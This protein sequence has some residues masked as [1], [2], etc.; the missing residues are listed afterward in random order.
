MQEQSFQMPQWWYRE[1]RPPSDDAYF[2][3]MSR[4]IIHAGL[5]WYVIDRKWQAIRRAFLGF[6]FEKVARF[7]E[8]DV[9]RLMMDK[10]IVRNRAKIIA[11]IQNALIFRQIV[12]QYGSFQ[13]YLDS[14]DKS[15]NYADAVKELRRKFKRLGPPSASLFLYSVGENINPW[16]Y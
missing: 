1:K 2:E 6:N 4:I 14:L 7:T 15:N 10:G 13:A 9:E 16:A 3:N 5:N 11:I 12:K 8:D